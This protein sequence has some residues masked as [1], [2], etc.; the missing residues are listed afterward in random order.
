MAWSVADH[1]GPSGYV[2]GALATLIV[3]LAHEWGHV[4]GARLAGARVALAGSLFS[5]FLFNFDAAAH[6]RR[7]FLHMAH[8]GFALTAIAVAAIWLLAG[9]SDAHR[10]A[11]WGISALATATVIFEFPIYFWVAAGRNPPDINLVK[12]G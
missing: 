11:R 9:T 1:A 7:Q 8:G 10:A 5:P 4:L 12:E 6:T 2:L 3:F